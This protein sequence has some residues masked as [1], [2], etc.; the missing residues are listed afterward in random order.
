[1]RPEHEIDWSQND[2]DTYDVWCYTCGEKDTVGGSVDAHEWA[3]EHKRE[4]SR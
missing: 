4:V 2:D 3:D 1:M